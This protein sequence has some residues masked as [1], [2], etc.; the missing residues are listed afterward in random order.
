MELLKIRGLMSGMG[1]ARHLVQSHLAL[2][3]P[4]SRQ[5][6]IPVGYWFFC[7]KF[8]GLFATEPNPLF[9]TF[10][11][12]QS[13]GDNLEIPQLKKVLAGDLLGG[14]TLDAQTINLLWTL[15]WRGTPQI[16]LEY[17]SGVSTIVLAV[18]A[19]LLSQRTGKECLVISLET[20]E[21]HKEAVGQRL[22]KNNLDEASKILHLL[23][24]DRG[25]YELGPLQDV[26][27]GATV[28]LVL[29]DGP[30]G[31]PGCRR[32]TLPAVL[33]YCKGG[34]QWLLDDAFRDGELEILRTWRRAPKIKIEGIFPVGKG[35]AVGKVR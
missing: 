2:L 29:I 30:S 31:P 27:A 7:R 21:R 15:L 11:S 34:T 35:L 19:S 32:D 18:Y 33:P 24:S 3:G 17:G 26:L 1:I 12:L 4:S 25:I 16:I 20:D 10:E 6:P 9:P 13:R 14:W 28:D 8:L 5:F 22:K 23:R